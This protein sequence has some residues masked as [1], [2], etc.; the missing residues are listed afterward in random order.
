MQKHV[1]ALS[2]LEAHV[3][4]NHVPAGTHV[5][6][7]AFDE[8]ATRIAS[9]PSTLHVGYCSWELVYTAAGDLLATRRGIE[10]GDIA[11]AVSRSFPEC[12]C[13]EPDTDTDEE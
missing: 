11:E 3:Y 1:I 6:G 9:I 5:H 4:M 13:D 10:F 12:R 2:G 8:N 7:I